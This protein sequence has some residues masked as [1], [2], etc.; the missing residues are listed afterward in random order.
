[1]SSPKGVSSR[2]ERRLE[3]SGQLNHGTAVRPGLTAFPS[4]DVWTRR[5]RSLIPDRPWGTDLGFR[6]EKCSTWSIEVLICP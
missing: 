4:L 5:S 2:Q 3:L 6:G 1:M